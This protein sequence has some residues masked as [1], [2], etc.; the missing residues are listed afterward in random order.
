[1][2]VK[3][4]RTVPSEDRSETIESARSGWV[5]I[6]ERRRRERFPLRLAVSVFRHGELLFEG[7]TENI[8]CEGLYCLSPMQ[9]PVG[10]EVRCR[11]SLLGSVIGQGAEIFLDCATSVVRAEQREVV[12]GIAF[13]IVNYTA[14]PRASTFTRV[15]GRSLASRSGENV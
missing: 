10:Q 11:L 9:L 13:H 8:S 15:N 6:S 3:S 7:Q 2:L 5:I 14:E 12:Y 4:G 1:M